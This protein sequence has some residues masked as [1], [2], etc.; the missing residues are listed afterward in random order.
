M[1]CRSHHHPLVASVWIACAHPS[2]STMWVT[3][4]GVQPATSPTFPPIFAQFFPHLLFPPATA[5]HSISGSDPFPAK[6]SL[7]KFGLTFLFISVPAPHLSKLVKEWVKWVKVWVASV[8]AQPRD[9]PHHQHQEEAGHHHQHLH[10]GLLEL[11]TDCACN[12]AFFSKR[13]QFSQSSHFLLFYLVFEKTLS[14]SLSVQ[15]YFVLEF[16][17]VDS[18][19]YHLIRICYRFRW[20]ISLVTLWSKSI[21]CSGGDGDAVAREFWA[22]VSAPPPP[23]SLALLLYLRFASQ[24]VH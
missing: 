13:G 6:Y 14:I 10:L 18:A 20:S 23:T 8:A 24:L 4:R 1:S 11:F 3:T 17:S 22:G 7:S 21:W 12:C 5:F 16:W 15:F 19:H 2:H 9:R